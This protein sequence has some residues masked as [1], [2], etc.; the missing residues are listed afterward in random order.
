MSL[1][2]CDVELEE[3]IY[4]DFNFTL[5]LLYDKKTNKCVGGVLYLKE[6]ENR[7]DPVELFIDP[8]SLP[9]ITPLRLNAAKCNFDVKGV[10]GLYA[11]IGRKLTLVE[12]LRKPDLFMIPKYAD[13]MVWLYNYPELAFPEYHNRLPE[14]LKTRIKEYLE[15]MKVQ[16]SV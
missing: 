1:E 3:G 2:E 13:P 14:N 5:R 15:K 11:E 12:F 10:E 7:I 6:K 16:R 8:K 9:D 4:G